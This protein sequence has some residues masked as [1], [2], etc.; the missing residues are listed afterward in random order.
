MEPMRKRFVLAVE[1]DP[2]VRRD[3]TCL[4][5]TWAYEPV[6]ASSVDE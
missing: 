1:T 3:L 4:L 2:V 5:E 6:V